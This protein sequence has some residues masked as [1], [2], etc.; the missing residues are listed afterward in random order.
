MNYYIV[1]PSAATFC[2]SLGWKYAHSALLIG[3]SNVTALLALLYY[4]CRLQAP[5]E[6]SFKK[7]LILSALCPLVGNI[8][9]VKGYEHN[10][11]SVSILGRL[12]IGFS[13]ADM[14]N[15]QLVVTYRFKGDLV[16]EL[17]KIRMVQLISIF[18]AI[19]MGTINFEEK[20]IF[21]HGELFIFDF[22][23]ISGYIMA[24]AWI[25]QLL[26][27]TCSRF[28]QVMPERSPPDKSA[29]IY[30]SASEHEDPQQYLLEKD[31]LLPGLLARAR[32]VS[33]TEGSNINEA[34]KK[35][36]G[37]Q[38]VQVSIS[39][40]IKSI[41]SM[42]KKTKKLVLHNIA[43]PITFLVYGFVC[44]SIEIYLTSSVIITSRYF[45]WNGVQGGRFLAL[46]S[47]WVLPTYFVM[48]YAITQFG[49]RFVIKKSLMVM[50]FGIL[51]FVN[52]E[53][54]YIL[55]E[56]IGAIFRQ[57]KADEPLTT[58]YDWEFGMPQ[59]CCSIIVMFLASV[60]LEGSSLSLLSKVSPDKLNRS[61]INCA[62]IVPIISYLGRI[63]GDA[64]I[65][66]VG[67]SHR[68]I[69][70]D[71]VNSISFVLLALCYCCYHVVK[72]HYFFLTGS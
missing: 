68:E 19:L 36:E 71:L 14:I 18:T 58:Y 66:A 17:T 61:T 16:S 28:P 12:L 44:L 13:S 59:Y 39:D 31:Y 54:L 29:E 30:L 49:E 67:F 47:F 45:Q 23:T 6:V 34:F 10:L 48:S 55:F 15:K 8:L 4:T 11:F 33:D 38:R 3:S 51:L 65:V 52:Y 26:G 25:L 56:H 70:T 1:L 27:L 64:V 72:K 40:Q 5:Q 9:Y 20:R 69:N 62:V 60:T 32:S 24:V 37:E 43:L 22:N 53:A 35:K 63:I 50:F 57:D 42:L 46:L 41:V 7:M 21:I 2:C